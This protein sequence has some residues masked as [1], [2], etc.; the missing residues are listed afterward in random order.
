MIDPE[1]VNQIISKVIE[2]A[3]NQFPWDAGYRVDLYDAVAAGLT[4]L[5]D[6]L[7]EFDDESGPCAGT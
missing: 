4:E 2:E 1:L 6:G 3:M 7:K 5:A